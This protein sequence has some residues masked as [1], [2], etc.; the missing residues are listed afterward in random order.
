MEFKKKINRK[1]R[2]CQSNKIR[3]EHVDPEV[4]KHIV[5][6]NGPNFFGQDPAALKWEYAIVMDDRL[7]QMEALVQ[8]RHL[9]HELC[10]MYQ[11]FYDNFRHP[12]GYIQYQTG[13]FER[14][15]KI[16]LPEHFSS[17]STLKK[18]FIQ[19]VREA[20]TQDVGEFGF[21]P[22]QF[23]NAK[24]YMDYEA[25]KMTKDMEMERFDVF[26][27]LRNLHGAYM[28]YKRC[29]GQKHAIEKLKQA[30]S[31]WDMIKYLTLVERINQLEARIKILESK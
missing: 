10:S 3:M 9:P 21:L 18:Q 28:D 22:A 17:S 27:K 11:T 13:E 14:F 31:Y 12:I 30:Q 7:K 5:V 23:T 8:S 29:G 15:M 6:P 25:G 24:I 19:S 26:H 1:G 20:F 2:S 16:A 4:A